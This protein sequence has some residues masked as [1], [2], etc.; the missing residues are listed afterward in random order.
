MIF[1]WLASGVVVF[2]AA[3]VVFVVIG[4]FLAL[5]WRWLVWLHVPAVIWAVLLEY[6]G[7]ICPLTPLENTLRARAG[8]AGYSGGFIEHYILR[9]LYPARLTSNLRW[10]LGTFA[11][12][13]NIVAYS[14]I[15]RSR[16][17]AS[18]A[19]T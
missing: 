4:G 8:M 1:H 17:A 2:H 19:A 11:L 5:R 15:I 7:W 3:F 16:R 6:N 14:L 9:E 12:V 13:V 10:G 18:K